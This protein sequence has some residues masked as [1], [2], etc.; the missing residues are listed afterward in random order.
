MADDLLSWSVPP[1]PDV[2]M[3][4]VATSPSAAGVASLR[5]PASLVG[6]LGTGGGSGK[7]VH[8]VVAHRSS[9]CLGYIGNTRSKI[10]LGPKDCDIK[11]HD[12]ERFI[13]PDGIQ[14]LVF[15]GTG[16]SSPAA[17]AAPFVELGWFGSTWYRYE[18]ELRNVTQRQT[19]LEATS[20]GPSF[21]EQDVTRM[22]DATRSTKE[23]F[24]PFKKRRK[25][26]E[27]DNSIGG[28]VSS[29]QDVSVIGYSPLRADVEVSRQ[30]RT[31]IQNFEWLWKMSLAAKKGTDKLEETIAEVVMRLE[32]KIG[33]LRA[34]W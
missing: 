30:E 3:P 27:E 1:V 34:H 15:I 25:S 7:L 9:T 2:D 5:P 33:E 22:A 12:R 14:D 24:T 4:P 26:D 23:M 32:A 28:S 6:K 10:C 21:T 11:S 19:L 31:V 16:G 20:S 13:F 18:L 29:Y 8:L 17:W